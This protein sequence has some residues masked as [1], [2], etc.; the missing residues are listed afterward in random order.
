MSDFDYFEVQIF[1]PGMTFQTNKL[2]EFLK[3]QELD[4]E[5]DIEYSVALL[6]HH[7]IVA[8]GSYAG[9]IL[10]CIAVKNDYK[11]M[12][13]SSKIISMLVSS[14][15]SRGIDHLFLFTKHHNEWMFS[16]LGFY[17]IAA[18]NSG[19]ILLENKKN[20]LKKYIENLSHYKS[21]T[22]D[23]GCIVANCNPFTLGHKHLITY[24]ANKCD[25]LHVFV[26]SEDRSIFPSAI[27]YELIEKGTAPIKNIILHYSGDYILSSATFPSY[28]IKDKGIVSL[29]HAQLDLDLF[30]QHIA[31]ALGITKRFVGTEPSCLTT[32]AYNAAMTSMLPNYGIEVVEIPRLEQD[33][34]IISA[35]KVRAL[36][37]SGHLEKTKAYVP[38]TTYD[39]FCS[40]EGKKILSKIQNTTIHTHQ[41]R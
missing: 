9:K 31:P 33:G 27:R 23:I 24:A 35:S 4:Y 13:L 12:G 7:E 28:F 34:E 39:F 25:L 2:I 8:S 10:K 3:N 36:I 22:S 40:K 1:L 11:H 5:N 20:G 15:Y 19:I 26:V 16:E 6:D 37:A 38:Q 41:G 30:T 21:N 17:K 29:I 32:A 18:S 14:Q